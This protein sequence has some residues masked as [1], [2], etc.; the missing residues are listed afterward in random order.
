MALVDHSVGLGIYTEPKQNARISNGDSFDKPLLLT[1]DGVEGGILDTRLYLGSNDNVHA[2]LGADEDLAGQ[3]IEIYFDD[4][5]NHTTGTTP[6]WYWKL[7]AGD[8]HPTENEWGQAAVGI[9][10][11]VGNLYNEFNS[12]DGG[13]Q[14]YL[15]FWLRTNIPA[16]TNAQMISSVKLKIVGTRMDVGWYFA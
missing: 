10:V 12:Y 13:L 14:T 3:G 11:F 7:K 15:P 2:Y 8:K 16:I 5:D 1:Q 4:P 6:G 9:G